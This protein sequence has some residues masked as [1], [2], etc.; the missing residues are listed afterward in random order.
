MTGVR[1]QASGVGRQGSGVR[2]QE[3]ESEADEFDASLTS[4]SRPP[5]P[6]LTPVSRLLT[7]IFI[8]AILLFP[9]FAHGCHRGDH[10]DEPAFAPVK[11]E[12]TP[13]EF[14]HIAR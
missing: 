3:S 13:P 7:P 2:G 12:R 8:A 6:E 9:I 11:T 14:D 10:D 5:N 4:D 1:D